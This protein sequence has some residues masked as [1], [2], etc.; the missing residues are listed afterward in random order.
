MCITGSDSSWGIY[1]Q[2]SDFQLCWK[3]YS[4]VVLCYFYIKF[5]FYLIMHNILVDETSACTI[6]TIYSITYFYR[7]CHLCK[8]RFLFFYDRISHKISDYYYFNN[9]IYRISFLHLYNISYIILRLS[10]V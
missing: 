5:G 9:S 10:F 7:Y 3:N 6:Y 8:L 4:K 1:F 2:S